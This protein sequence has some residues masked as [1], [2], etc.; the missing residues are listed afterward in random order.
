MSHA[1]ALLVILAFSLSIVSLPLLAQ[2]ASND[3][4]R[5]G[6]A[7]DVH[8]HDTDSPG[9]GKVMVNYAER[10]QA[11]ID[12]MNSASVDA[13]VQLGDLVNGN[14]VF[15]GTIGDPARIEGLLVEA[16][17]LLDG[18]GGPV[19]HVPG[20]HDFYNLSLD[21]YLAALSLDAAHYSFDL[22]AFHFVVLDAEHNPDGTHYDDVYLRVKGT[23]PPEHLDWLRTDLEA[24]ERPTIVLIH[25]PLDSDF[26]ALAGG[27]PVANHL[28]VRDVLAQSGTVIAVFQG[29]DHENRHTVIDGI[30]YLTFA[31]MVD[32]SEPTPPSWALVTLDADARS[33][34][35]EGEGLQESY[36]LSY[37]LAP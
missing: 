15:D 20:N 3:V 36:S 24:T 28:E 29:H 11:F 14:V 35:I 37:T 23:I 32:H 16:G 2:D 18:F 27:P 4:V 12:A 10:L 19:Y 7:T 13:V 1:R 30:H 22:G 6:V 26:D 8:V 34:L 25:Q 9:E 33:I 17:D 21:K 5:V 31:A